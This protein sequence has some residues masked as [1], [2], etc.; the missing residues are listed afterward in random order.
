LREGQAGLVNSATRDR[1]RFEWDTKVNNTLG[2]WLT[3]GGWNGYHHVV[4]EPI[5]GAPDPLDVAAKAG[6][7]GIVPPRETL[8]LECQS[9]CQF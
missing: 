2:L 5:N 1:L 9:N 6:R 8:F 3:R 4:L 7:C